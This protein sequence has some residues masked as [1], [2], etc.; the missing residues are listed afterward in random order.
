M[1]ADIEGGIDEIIV[2]A[3]DSISSPQQQSPRRLAK[4][5]D[6]SRSFRN[7]SSALSHQEKSMRLLRRCPSW[8]QL[9]D[10]QSIHRNVHG[11][12]K[13]TEICSNCHN[14]IVWDALSNN[15]LSFLSVVVAAVRIGTHF[16]S[17]T[18]RMNIVAN[19]ISTPFDQI[20]TW[21]CQRRDYYTAASIALSLLDDA[22]AVYELCRIPKSSEEELSHHKGLLDG[23]QSLTIDNSHG[24]KSEMLTYLADMTVACLIKGSASSVLEGF[25]SRVRDFMVAE[26]LLHL[27]RNMRPH[28]LTFFSEYTLQCISHMHHAC[29]NCRISRVKRACSE[30]STK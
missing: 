17:L 19:P 28:S 7:K 2:D 11:Q 22:D 10:T 24:N 1:A 13:N 20:L 6:G 27:R 4:S 5:I 30:A 9:D 29:W 8:T 26:Y 25:L 15:N 14:C 23:I 21:L 12:G 3:L 16:Q 18:L